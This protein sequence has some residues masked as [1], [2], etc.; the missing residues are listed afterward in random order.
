MAKAVQNDE[1][2]LY[3]QPKILSKTD[4]LAGVEVLVRWQPPEGPMI[5]PNDFIPLAEKTNL[6]KD[7]TY[8]V[9]DNTFKQKRIWE[10]EN[11]HF[12]IAIN[13][14]PYL[15][16]DLLIP[17]K[18]EELIKK[19]GISLDN[20]CFEITETGMIN[21]PEIAMD[22]LT[23]LGIKGFKLSIDDFGTGYSS[24]VE[25]HKMPFSELKIDKSFVMNLLKDEDA[26]I[27]TRSIVDLGHNLGLTVVA[28]GV[29][30]EKTIEK[31]KSIHCDVLQGYY[32]SKPIPIAE[33]NQ[34][35]KVKLDNQLR[36]NYGTKS[37]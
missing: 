9:I 7:L 5:F 29:E 32:I 31:L 17:D 30:N 13:L 27:I 22:I 15:L 33:F 1:L 14:S 26:W 35:I 34:W 12:G 36:F 10:E 20:I 16:N 23:R 21:K 2:V 6:I 19:H 37:T 3:Y 4:E 25:L 24:L 8:W 18:V 11:L 28:E